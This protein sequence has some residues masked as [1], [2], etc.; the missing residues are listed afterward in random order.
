MSDTEPIVPLRPRRSGAVAEHYQARQSDAAPQV[1]FDRSELNIILDIYGLK[2]A[3]GE[4]RDYAMDFGR[5]AAVFSVFRRTSEVPLYRIVKQP[6]LARK[7]GMYS[8]VA[9]GSVVLRRGHDLKQVL[10]VFRKQPK[11]VAVL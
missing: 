1:T 2:V 8:V 9:P 5:D 4:W 11:L 6:K 3:E 10:R 7:Q